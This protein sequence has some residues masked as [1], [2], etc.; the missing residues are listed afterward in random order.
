MTTHVPGYAAHL[1]EAMR[2]IAQSQMQFEGDTGEGISTTRWSFM[3]ALEMLTTREAGGLTAAQSRLGA[4]R[5]LLAMILP[6]DHGGTSKLAEPHGGAT[7]QSLHAAEEAAFASLMAAEALLGRRRIGTDAIKV[8][9]DSE[10]A[11]WPNP[12]AATASAPV[13]ASEFSATLLTD[14]LR[15][16]LD[17]P[18]LN[19]TDLKQLRG[20][21]HKET[22][23]F[24]VESRCLAGEFV[25]RRDSSRPLITSACHR[26][27]KE[28]EVL[29]ALQEEH[30]LSPEVLWLET[31]HDC[32]PGADFIVMRRSEGVCGGTLFGASQ[33][34]EPAFSDQIGVALARLHTLPPLTRLGTLTERIRP[35]MWCRP[36]S[37]LVTDYLVDFREMLATTLHSPSPATAAVL[38]WLIDNVPTADVRPS[39][40]HGDVGFHNLLIH[41]GELTTV[42]DWERAHVGHP[43]EDIA[44]L[45]NAAAVDLDWDRV[46]RAYRSNGGID[47]SARDLLYFRIMMLARNAVSLNV[48]ASRLL[49]GEVQYLRL[50]AA[51]NF[52]RP[53]VLSSIAKLIQDYAK[54]DE[55]DAALL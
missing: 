54:L 28:F 19:V 18:S 30:Y 26:V 7:P 1:L 23:L 12:S 22:Y 20:G 48:G 5:D 11:Q 36:A 43:A 34:V 49:T 25:I 10:V 35:D 9:C 52:M 8:L 29:K 41:R 33:S 27:R 42:L 31:Q 50:L 24:T 15:A 51:E 6:T 55:M 46:M 37:E 14:Y 3:S 21:F 16:R 4:I 13:S 40:V 53:R 17:E 2:S 38:T 32:I 39:L 47:L 45:F 44:Y